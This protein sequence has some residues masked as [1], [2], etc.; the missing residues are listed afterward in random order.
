[1][2]AETPRHEPSPKTVDTPNPSGGEALSQTSSRPSLDSL[3]Q[4]KS[5]LQPPV[6]FSVSD[7][8][9]DADTSPF[10]LPTGQRKLPV[11]PPALLEQPV[12]SSLPAETQNS[13]GPT[14]PAF[15]QE[16][17]TPHPDQEDRGPSLQDIPQEGDAAA[18]RILTFDTEHD[19]PAAGDAGK[20]P[21]RLAPGP[22]KFSGVP[23]DTG[24]NDNVTPEDKRS[25][26]AY[27]RHKI[28]RTAGAETIYREAFTAE[29][30]LKRVNAGRLREKHMR[31]ESGFSIIA[32]N[33]AIIYSVLA[34]GGTSINDRPEMATIGMRH[35]TLIPLFDNEGALPVDLVEGFSLVGGFHF[36]YP[37]KYF[38][39]FSNRDMEA[40]EELIQNHRG[41]ENSFDARSMWWGVFLSKP[42]GRK[43]ETVL[44]MFQGP[45]KNFAY[46]AYDFSRLIYQR[47]KEL[48]EQSGMRTIITDIPFARG[49]ADL[50][51]LAAALRQNSQ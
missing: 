47:Q 32:S 22:N 27:K 43:M 8:P 12:V 5:S 48:L 36:H 40:Y 51:P 17:D 13:G 38:G 21:D 42:E 37:R 41:Q 35:S 6:P 9:T 14:I 18:P 16:I 25:V 11:F 23:Q 26:S 19:L 39:G 2:A 3:P 50:S 45:P 28:P 10:A 24:H 49:A 30:F 34:S 7:I 33:E 15:S 44:F 20:N 31:A 46:Q 29:P 1:M 4:R